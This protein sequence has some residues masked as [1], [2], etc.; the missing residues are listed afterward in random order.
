MSSP[1]SK[2]SESPEAKPTTN[3]TIENDVL[4]YLQTEFRLRF[5]YPLLA[6]RRG[7]QG[8]VIVAMHVLPTGKIAGLAIQESS[9]YPLLDHNALQT[10]ETIGLVKP[11]LRQHNAEARQLSVPVI[12][13][14]TGG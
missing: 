14:L 9:G 13:Q 7:W 4:N 12:Y 2:P 1:A 11:M 3:S 10:F 8:R 6:K 5:Q